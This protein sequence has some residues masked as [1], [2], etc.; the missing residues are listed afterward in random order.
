[1]VKLV[2]KSTQESTVTALFTE[3]GG[4]VLAPGVTDTGQI[5][6]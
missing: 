5:A 1:M 3:F 6:D 4:D 2:M